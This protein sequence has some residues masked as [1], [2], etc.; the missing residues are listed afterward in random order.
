MV[1]ITPPVLTRLRTNWWHSA[2][3]SAKS[4]TVCVTG[5]FP[6]ALLGRTNPDGNPEDGTVVPVPEDQLP[7]ILPEDVVMD[8]ITSPIKADPG[9][10][11]HHQRSACT[12]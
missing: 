1:W 4:T 2:S 3:A 6:S 12:A 11:N 9:G 7:V 5:G 10:Q 8:G